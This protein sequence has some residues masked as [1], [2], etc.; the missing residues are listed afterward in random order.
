MLCF[1]TNEWYFWSNITIIYLFCFNMIASFWTWQM[2]IF[3]LLLAIRLASPPLPFHFFT[4]F[5]EH[6][7]LTGVMVTSQCIMFTYSPRHFLK[8]DSFL[9]IL[10][11]ISIARNESSLIRRLVCSQKLFEMLLTYT[12]QN[13]LHIVIIL[14]LILVKY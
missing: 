13:H 12:F 6:I 14:H 4:Y 3:G 7:K 10:Y 1:I 5:D 9:I 8:S 11:V 2:T